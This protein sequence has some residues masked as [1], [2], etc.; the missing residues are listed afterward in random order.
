MAELYRRNWTTK[1]G[2][3][4]SRVLGGR[5]N[6]FL[7]Q[8]EKGFL[9]IDSGGY[10]GWKTL[11]RRLLRMGVS[12][13]APLNLVLTHSHFDHARNAAALKR[14]FGARILVHEKEA[15]G[16]CDGGNPPIQGS[17]RFFRLLVRAGERCGILSRMGFSG[18]R[19]DLKIGDSLDLSPYGFPAVVIHTPGHT[20]GSISVIVDHE[21]ALVGDTIFGVF[22]G[23]AY[24]PFAADPE[25][26]L[27]SWK[28]LLDSGCSLFLPAHGR[29]RSRALLRRAYH[30]RNPRREP[31][32]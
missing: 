10:S 30:Q 27:Q 29:L 17:N 31:S 2:A 3:R 16:L 32:P 23:S 8:G 24:P 12:S 21:I 9:L 28:K 1:G 26:L 6:C 11:R 15:A 4:V 19:P 25:Q 7:V 13:D 5:C 22:P 20:P 18:V 14:E